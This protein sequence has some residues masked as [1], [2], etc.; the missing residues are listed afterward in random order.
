MSLFDLIPLSRHLEEIEKIQV[1]HRRERQRV[2]SQHE[3]EVE[4]LRG[5]VARCGVIKV[6]GQRPRPDED[7]YTIQVY[8]TAQTLHEILH[9]GRDPKAFVRVLAMQFAHEA[10][11]MLM[12][13]S[14]LKKIP[15]LPYHPE[16]ADG[17]WVVLDRK[18]L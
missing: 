17:G 12:A 9:S 13:L 1:D 11:M 8:C 5:L 16:S 2:N 7:R 18:E 10:E 14:G 15:M 3:K 6:R 4:R